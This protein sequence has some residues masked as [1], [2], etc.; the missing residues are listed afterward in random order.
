MVNR[1]PVIKSMLKYT[2]ICIY[3]IYIYRESERE[4]WSGTFTACGT[5]NAP[6]DRRDENYLKCFSHR[7]TTQVEQWT[8]KQTNLLSFRVVLCLLFLI[9]IVRSFKTPCAIF[10]RSI[11]FSLCHLCV[12]SRIRANMCVLFVLI[13]VGSHI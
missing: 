11:A 7:W 1:L 12:E 8:N 2:Y 4:H 9:S 6:C 5:T 3:Y 10:I 13:M